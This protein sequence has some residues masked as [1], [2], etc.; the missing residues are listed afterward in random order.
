MTPGEPPD[1]TDEVGLPISPDEQRKRARDWV[2]K[3]N[4]PLVSGD[5]VRHHFIPQSFLRRFADERDQLAVVRLD[6]PTVATVT[7]VT[8]IAVVRHLYT[9]VNVGVGETVATERVLA[10]VDH[11]A[12][13]PIARLGGAYPFPLD[14]A[15][16][17][18]VALWLGLLWVRDPYTRRRMEAI[19]DA[20]AKM[21]WSIQIANERAQ[22][23][24]EPAGTGPV[25]GQPDTG[26]TMED[27]DDIE[28]SPHQNEFVGSVLDTGLGL[29]GEFGA[30]FFAVVRFTNP[31]LVLADR[32]M[33]LYVKPDG[34]P[35]FLGVGPA[36]ADE[37][38]IPIDRSTALMLHGHADIGDCE[39]DANTVGLTATAFNQCAVS[40]AADEVY[41]H[42]DELPALQPLELP[43]S[44]RPLL[45]IDGQMP[46]A[47]TDGVN[48][49]PKRRGYRR[50]RKPKEES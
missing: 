23:D 8:N 43:S 31:G 34:L 38:W 20:I 39:I 25:P 37:V 49:P 4:R 45:Q 36:T 40:A 35:P 6:E 7:N 5:P 41:C 19:A 48:A 15:D 50:Y 28:I 18:S 14:D 30:R 11:E 22:R 44:E 1:W 9:T 3:A 29:A 2:D 17:L 21:G 12:V 24:E 27:L 10:M 13:A 46:M 33:W 47:E 16:R 42:P 26:L 32:P